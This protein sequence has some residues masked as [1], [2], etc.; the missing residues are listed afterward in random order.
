M[1]N[2]FTNFYRFMLTW[3]GT[4]IQRGNWD[5]LLRLH[6]FELQGRRPSIQS[7]IWWIAH[8]DVILD[9]VLRT[10]EGTKWSC[11]LKRI[12]RKANKSPLD[13]IRHGRDNLSEWINYGN[14]GNSFVTVSDARTQRSSAL[15]LAQS[16]KT[17]L[18]GF[19][20]ISYYFWS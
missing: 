15:S 17:Q 8:A 2:R 5:V 7:I 4:D 6:S 3:Q 16:S 14:I 9:A 1:F 19:Q 11:E 12:S 13:T 20:N 18:Q 10:L